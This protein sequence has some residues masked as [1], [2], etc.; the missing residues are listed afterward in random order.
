MARKDRI[1]M[2]R[3]AQ[4]LELY[5]RGYSIRRIAQT[6]HM[7]KKSVRKYIDRPL[8]KVAV[9]EDLNSPTDSENPQTSDQS[10]VILQFP[11]WLQELDWQTLL[12]EKSKGVPIKVLYEEVVNKGVK[13]WT[14]WNTLKRL[15]ASLHPE[16][17]KTTMRLIHKPGEKAFVDYGDGIDILNVGAVTKTWIFVGTLPFSSKVFAEFVFDQ[18][19]PSFISSHEKMWKY[20]GGVTSY[21]VSD[22]LK[23]AV[24]KAHM[25]DPDLNKTY[26][27]YA[28]H[29][30][31]AALPARSRKP[32]DKANV[33]CHVGILQRSFF[34]E[35][36]NKSFHSISEL[37]NAL[38]KHLEI[39]NNQ[40]M[41]DHGVSRNQ[42]F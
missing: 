17:P 11:N 36:R 5:Q 42:R 32:K 35:V 20:F 22:N 24:I 29:A 41:K 39:L 31:F 16:I 30:G 13:Y 4:I 14:F 18:K 1:S 21:T 2:D 10:S 7:C 40:V 28:N 12:S 6:L 33:E 26:V 19:L 8:L 23:S 3:H 9:S 34:Q 37:N 38:T 25:Y 15:S 27:A